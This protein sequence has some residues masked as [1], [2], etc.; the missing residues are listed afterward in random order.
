M[1]VKALVAGHLCLDLLPTFDGA[2]GLAEGAL[3]PVGPMA[4]R[5]GG[6]VATTGRTLAALGVSSA[7]A[8]AVGDDRLAA[9]MRSLLAEL[10]LPTRLVEVPG[11]TSYSVVLQPP[12]RDRTFWHHTGAN[13][14]FDGVGLDLEGIDLLHLG[15]PNLLPALLPDDGMPLRPLLMRARSGGATTSVD[16]AVCAPDAV[17][18]DWER[19][20]ANVLPLTDVLTPS[21]DDLNSALGWGLPPTLD[22]LA[23][24]TERLVA[25]GAGIVVVSGGAAGLHV[26]TAAPERVADVGAAL[27]HGIPAGVSAFVPAP[28]VERVATTTGAGDVA[29]AG[30][31][32]ALVHGGTPAEA[33]E[34][35]V[36]VAVAHVEGRPVSA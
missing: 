30:F 20:L 36:Q 12:G 14:H 28:T 5:L 10:G 4:V 25:L 29:T 15:Y 31:L 32:A 8:A 11:S 19:V 16:L 6:C 27:G 35:A 21:L 33:A 26:R 7:L 18:P 24:A 23:E 9:L 13:D 34:A 2:P 3:Y 1:T 17:G 22:S